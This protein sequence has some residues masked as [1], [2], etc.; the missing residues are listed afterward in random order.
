MSGVPARGRGCR[1]WLPLSS[2]RCREPNARRPSRQREEASQI[3]SAV[4]PSSLFFLQYFGWLPGSLPAK[5]PD[6]GLRAASASKALGPMPSP[7]CYAG[8]P[9]DRTAAFMSRKDPIFFAG[10]LKEAA[11]RFLLLHRG[12]IVCA[13]SSASSLPSPCMLRLQDLKQ[14]GLVLDLPVGV[15][16]DCGSDSVDG[17]E[18]SDPLLVR[19]ITARAACV[20]T[21]LGRDDGSGS[22]GGWVL[23]VEAGNVVGS[24]A[25][26]ARLQ[27][28]PVGSGGGSDGGG[29]GG[30]S[31]G[32]MQLIGGRGLHH[33]LARR[34]DVALCGFAIATTAWQ[35]RAR[36]CGATGERTVPIEA[37]V[38][39][40]TRLPP[41]RAAAGGGGGNG[42]R[43]RPP[44]WYARVDP[45]AIALV[46]SDC[47]Q[48]CLLSR[49]SR[50][51]RN[52]FTCLAGFIEPC[53]TV[54][55]AVR[56]EVA[57]EADI[58]LSSVSMHSSQPWPVGR[59]GCELMLACR[60]VAAAGEA[61]ERIQVQDV[62]S[63]DAEYASAEDV[64]WFSR[65]E[66]RAM[67]ARSTIQRSTGGPAKNDVLPGSSRPGDGSLIVP[68]PY[69]VAHVLLQEW[70]AEEEVATHKYAARTHGWNHACW[71]GLG[72]GL[73][74]ALGCP[75]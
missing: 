42:R 53:E 18:G 13:G 58:E 22:D 17:G 41:S 31:G 6:A 3:R 4:K 28:Q 65:D 10:V 51:R 24:E 29:G 23:A 60:A 54:E 25:L 26:L 33:S 20:V 1:G 34:E 30:S 27:Q 48:R 15:H 14:A 43:A 38:K 57:E 45:C 44:R 8:V 39:R 12:S 62:G 37:G 66:V 19:R 36:Y 67:L 64:R 35:S 59:A 71:L 5:T 16:C 50:L 32:A 9:L 55:E 74:F 73:G 61:G 7:I 63:A 11:T 52:M 68:G 47:G 49:P 40:E 69:A 72:L 46:V 70:V 56:R 2:N 21:L 75:R